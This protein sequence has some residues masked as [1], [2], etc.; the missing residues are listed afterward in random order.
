MKIITNNFEI[1]FDKKTPLII[2][3][4]LYI[5]A[6]SLLPINMNII[7]EGIAVAYIIFGIIRCRGNLAIRLSVLKLIAFFIPF[8]L[9]ITVMLF[10]HIN[11]Q[12]NYY[13]GFIETYNIVLRVF[14]R[15][16]IVCF[17]YLIYCRRNN[18]SIN[19]WFYIIYW[20]GVIQVIFVIL[21]LLI[22]QFREIILNMIQQNSTADVV[23]EVVER[24][25]SRRGYGLASNLFDAFGY[26]LAFLVC[27][28]ILLWLEENDKRKIGICILLLVA[29][30]LNSRTGIL[31][32]LVSIVTCFVVYKKSY[33]Q[34][35][36]IIFALIIAVPIFLI[37]INIMN[38]FS[39]ETL[40][41]ISDGVEE[42]N[43]FLFE[44]EATGIFAAFRDFTFFPDDIIFGAGA[45]PDYLIRKWSDIGY[46]ICVWEYG[47]I[48]TILLLGGYIASLL[49]A[50]THATG[51]KEKSFSIAAIVVFLIYLYKIY[52]I[53]NLGANFIMFSFVVT[54]IFNNKN[55]NKLNYESGKQSIER[56][57]YEK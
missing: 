47:I 50:Y 21:T 53:G 38:F 1:K 40:Q 54:I 4:F 5:F 34:I 57:N 31:L 2:L 56:V 35:K 8:F 13:D 44:G 45:S 32:G 23:V 51:S 9:Y 29:N 12:P 25:S 28:T 7:I 30:L 43:K 42:L 15:G 6:P 27:V 52:S 49:Y 14:I 3:F 24:L 20:V 55:R 19:D 37:S 41:W 36:T 11:E 18:L 48:G 46:I 16:I 10:V 33:R 22:P 39:P 26:L 17:A